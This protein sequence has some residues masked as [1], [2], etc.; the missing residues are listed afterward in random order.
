VTNLDLARLQFASTSIYHFLFVPITI[1]LA[2][3][4][5]LLQT[6]W[7]R[8]GDEAY[9]RLTRFFGTL[10]VIII[11]IGVLTSLVQEFQFGM[12]WSSVLSTVRLSRGRLVPSRSVPSERV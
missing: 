10:L 4:V 12:N 7:H 2:F 5:A 3:L 1:G 6:T 8:R 11:A 9:L